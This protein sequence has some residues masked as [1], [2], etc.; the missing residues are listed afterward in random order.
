MDAL[1]PSVMALQCLQD[2][3]LAQ[4]LTTPTYTRLNMALLLTASVGVVVLAINLKYGVD[5]YGLG[6]YVKMAGLQLANLVQGFALVVAIRAALAFYTLQAAANSEKSL[7]MDLGR[8][9]VQLV[10]HTAKFWQ[11]FMG[12]AYAG[13]TVQLALLI[14]QDFAFRVTGALHAEQLWH[15]CLMLVPVVIAATLKDGADR[16]RL[17]AS[18]FRKLNLGMMGMALVHVLA[19]LAWN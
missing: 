6:K 11:S 4:R 15:G 16:G 10:T 8:T 17:G 19:A 7:V 12:A 18:T 3:A 14:K 9:L 13:L 2:A 5:S 1:I